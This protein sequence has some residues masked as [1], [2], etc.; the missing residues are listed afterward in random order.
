[1]NVGQTLA[2]EKG[3]TQVSQLFPLQLDR[4]DRDDNIGVIPEPVA[5]REGILTRQ[6]GPTV[7]RTER[8]RSQPT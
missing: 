3:K 7:F 5:R 8:G 1:M 6:Q 2:L 4:Q